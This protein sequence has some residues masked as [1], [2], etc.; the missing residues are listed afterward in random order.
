MKIGRWLLLGVLLVV[1]TAIGVRQWKKRHAASASARAASTTT[2]SAARTDDDASDV[3]APPGVRITVEVLNATR[4]RGL[5]RRA[6]LYL[7]DRG[8]DVVLIGTTN[9]QQ[10]ATVVLDRSHHPEWAQLI[11]RA[12]HARAQSR[13]DTSSDVDAT[14]VVGRDWTPPPEPFYP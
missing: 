2:A 9:R 8:F 6:T 5:G 3:H 11:A 12:M 10:D 4:T 14:V 1:G 13:P 7:R